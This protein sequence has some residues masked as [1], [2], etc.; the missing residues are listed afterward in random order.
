MSGEDLQ[1]KCLMG[2]TLR[3]PELVASGEAEMQ[4]SILFDR[5]SIKWNGL[6]G[7][8]RRFGF[9]IV[10]F[11]DFHVTFAAAA[12]TSTWTEAANRA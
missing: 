11:F 10:A 4:L 6:K 7:F 5:I 9:T 8:K 12:Y 1:L 3:L 2:F